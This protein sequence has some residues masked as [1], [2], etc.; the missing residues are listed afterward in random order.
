MKQFN[1]IFHKLRELRKSKI[2][3]GIDKKF[4]YHGI[5]CT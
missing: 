5:A 1:M 4:S 2:L 3:P